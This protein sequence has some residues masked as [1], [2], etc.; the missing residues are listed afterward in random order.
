MPSKS[1]IEYILAVNQHRHFGRAAKTCHVTQPTLS[2]GV[3]A[4]EEYLGVTIFDR[5]VQP[6]VP[7]ERGIEIIEQARIALG[8]LNKLLT[9]AQNQTLEISGRLTLGVIPTV[10][11]YL[12]PLFL[13]NFAASHPRLELEV[14]EMT[15]AEIIEALERE[16]IDVG[17]LALPIEG[18]G[19]HSITIFLEPFYLLVPTNHDLAKKKTIDPA[20]IDGKA[21]WLLEEGHCFRSQVLQACK[22]RGR[23]PALGNIRFES[24]SLETLKKIVAQGLGYTLVPH[25]AIAESDDGTDSDTRVISFTRPV[26]AREIGLLF[27]RTQ[28]KRKA[29]EALEASIKASVPRSLLSAQKNLMAIGI[30]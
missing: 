15:T 3:A 6:V 2:S 4:L 20:E 25:L 7:T 17:L 11:P 27:R 9:I 5:S 13:E 8:E 26:P 10:S 23:R 19:L 12:L 24:G 16:M 28:L 22:L 21:L 29:I 18:P 14:H 30:K 1:Q